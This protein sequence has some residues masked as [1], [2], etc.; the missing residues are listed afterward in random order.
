MTS[1]ATFAAAIVVKYVTLYCKAVLLIG[2]ESLM[3]NVNY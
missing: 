3:D 1:D 2:K